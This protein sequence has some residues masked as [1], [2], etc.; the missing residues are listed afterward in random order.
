MNK[1]IFFISLMLVSSMVFA[2]TVYDIQYTENAGDGT[3]PSPLADQEVTVTGIV[4]GANYN[5]DNKFFISDP[6]GGA[7]H[8][9]YVYD[10]LVGPALGDEVQVTG[11]VTEYYGLTELSY[12]TVDI[13]SSGNTVPAPIAVTTLNLVVPSQAEQYEG[14]VVQVDNVVVTEVQDDYGQ[15]FIDDGS[16]E[17]QV[18]DGFFYLD[19]VT[20]AIIIEE[21][22]EWARIIGCVDYSYDE[23]AINPRTADDL[24]TE[25][26]SQENTVIAPAILI[27]NYPNP[28]NP[29]TTINYSVK[30]ATNV[31]I[32]VYNMKG[33]EV[34]NLVSE[35]VS[36]GSHTAVWN[37]TDYS[38][39]KVTSGMYFY[40]LTAENHTSTKK[41]VL[42]K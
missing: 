14:C 15:W 19:E 11:T 37:G 38:G 6:E 3:Y 13:L 31:N 12:C 34:T 28:F 30:T 21:D 26:S 33:Q 32:T 4:T 23:Y 25:V 24:M 7:W 5:N 8:G 35:T 16:G 9:V 20:P 40:K 17:C 41:M 42:L 29:E 2:T 22:M 39:Q 1:V 10:Y 18:D 27:G 36:A